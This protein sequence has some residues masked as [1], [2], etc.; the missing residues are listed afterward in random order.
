MDLDEANY[1]YT[2]AIEQ[3][4]TATSDVKYFEGQKN[5]LNFEYWKK[6]IQK[7]IIKNNKK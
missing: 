4:N 2:K 3:D 5:V 1:W 6:V 7:K